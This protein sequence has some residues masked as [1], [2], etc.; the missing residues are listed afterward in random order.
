[1]TTRAAGAPEALATVV[2][3]AITMLLPIV[4]YDFPCSYLGNPRPISSSLPS[5]P[6]GE[7]LPPGKEVQTKASLSD[8]DGG[9]RRT[10]RDVRAQPHNFRVSDS[11]EKQSGFFS[12][13]Y[14]T[15]DGIAS[16]TILES[17]GSVADL[18]QRILQ[19]WAHNPHNLTT[20]NQTIPPALAVE[21][22]FSPFRSVG[23]A[24]AMEDFLPIVSV[25]APLNDTDSNGRGRN[26]RPS[27]DPCEGR[28]LVIGQRGRILE[29]HYRDHYE[30]L[31][32]D[33]FDND[34]DDDSMGYDK[35]DSPQYACQILR[36][37]QWKLEEN[38]TEQTE[39]ALVTNSISSTTT[40]ELAK[41]NHLVVAWKESGSILQVFGNGESIAS[42][43]LLSTGTGG[44]SERANLN[45]DFLRSWDQSFR[46]QVFSD[47]RRWFETRNPG[48]GETHTKKSGDVDEENKTSNTDVRNV[49]PGT[50][51]NVAIYTQQ[52]DKESVKNLYREG[53]EMREDPSKA[54]FEDPENPFEPLRLVASPIAS[55]TE[56]PSNSGA[57][58]VQGRSA[59]ISVGG[60]DVSNSTTSL[61]DTMVEIVNIPRYGD[62]IGPD[63]SNVRVGDRIRLEEGYART[64][65]IY[66]H[67]QKDYFSVPTTS[68]HGTLLPNAKLPRESFSYCLVS[69]RKGNDHPEFDREQIILGRS[70][71]V[72][73]EVTIFH[74]NHPPTL[75]GVPDEIIQPDRQ[76]TGPGTR[77]WATLGNHIILSDEADYDI[78]RVK[79]DIWTQNGTLTIDLEEQELQTLAKITKCANPSPPRAGGI[80]WICDGQKDRN[81]TFLATPSDVSR[82][83]SNLIYTALYWDQSDSIYLRVS[84]GTGGPCIDDD[85][86]FSLYSLPNITIRDDCF[87]AISEIHVPAMSIPVGRSSA[88]YW[89]DHSSWWISLLALFLVVLCTCCCAICCFVKFR[90]DKKLNSVAVAESNSPITLASPA[91]NNDDFASIGISRDDVQVVKFQMESAA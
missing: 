71:I 3:P 34:D 35:Q 74:R 63:N 5:S 51:H 2:I 84:D 14:R 41:L 7:L 15:I 21:V 13:P 37:T 69:V 88:S 65:L 77:P 16:K 43:N 26:A 87:Q 27:R 18:R 55:S 81:M 38:K 90:R 4:T 85:R 24:E 9:K 54:F 28:Q 78:D 73:Q 17:E 11:E 10:R 30:Y 68:F 20:S 32:D 1:M 56:D 36:L 22:W 80:D 75:R 31:S 59:L 76:P 40:K 67:V 60:L 79:I 39:Y 47:S 49:F 42:I 6:M 66:R 29:L 58:V 48:T 72:R 82:I 45:P 50:I 61:W 57:S 70:K 8:N 52:L 33:Y 89:R 44:G 62:L 25:A 19:L 12:C 46:L 86:R 83:L 91:S 64:G 53:V 23:D